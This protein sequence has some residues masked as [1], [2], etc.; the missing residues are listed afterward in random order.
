[1]ERD[2]VYVPRT[3]SQTPFIH[4]DHPTEEMPA[5][6][7]FILVRRQVIAFTAYL[8]ENMRLDQYGYN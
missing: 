4:E 8:G 7:L 1:M 6:T 5:Y 3:K 2:V